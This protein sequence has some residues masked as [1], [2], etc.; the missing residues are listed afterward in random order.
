MKETIWYY[1]KSIKE[2]YH[3]LQS[4]KSIIHAG[5]TW[6]KPAILTKYASV[7]DLNNARLNYF[8]IDKKCIRMGAMLT[9][10]DI[11]ENLTGHFKTHIL[12]DALR[13]SA[14]EP[15]RN[16]ITLGGSIFAFPI[17]SDIIGPLISL[18]AK[19]ILSGPDEKKIDLEEYFSSPKLKSDFLIKEV[20]IP[21]NPFNSF[22]YKEAKTHFD[23][24]SFTI[25]LAVQKS[26]KKLEH[27]SFILTGVKSKY[28]KLKEIED[29][30]QKKKKDKQAIENSINSLKL[31]FLNKNGRSPVYISS[32]VK[33]KLLEGIKKLSRV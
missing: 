33:S 17:W 8:S 4:E 1:P 26:E 7:V 2:A 30:F 23:Y 12:I 21:A 29:A 32:I 22:F 16:R 11:K 19:V 31:E 27:P 13:Q 20:I 28:M 15:L 3:I 24:A 18:G 5:G 14:A 6:L 25:S 9:F 10:N